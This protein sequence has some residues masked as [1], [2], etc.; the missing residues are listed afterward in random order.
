MPQKNS[1]YVLVLIHF[2]LVFHINCNPKSLE[3]CKPNAVYIEEWK[4]FDEEKIKVVYCKS[5][6]GHCVSSNHLTGECQECSAIYNL[7]I[8]GVSG[9]YCTIS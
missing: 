5:T 6:V 8:N 4:D 9:N 2:L 1:Y 7:H 3:D